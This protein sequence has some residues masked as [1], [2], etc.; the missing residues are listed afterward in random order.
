MAKVKKLIPE[1]LDGILDVKQSPRVTS[2]SRKEEYFSFPVNIDLKKVDGAYIK[3]FRTYNG[4]TQSEFAK[5]I[6]ANHTQL[7]QWENDRH[8]MRPTSVR[9]IVEQYPNFLTYR[10]Q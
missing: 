4:L 2:R 3:S 6:G 10:D 7:N 1:S 5:S 8:K 9:K